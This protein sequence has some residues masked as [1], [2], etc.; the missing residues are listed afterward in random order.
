[1][2]EEIQVGDC[3][4][5]TNPQRTEVYRVIGKVTYIDVGTTFPYILSFDDS[6]WNTYGNQGG[7]QEWELSLT[8]PT[9]QRYAESRVNSVIIPLL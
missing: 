2:K 3:V 8:P 5:V 9:M 6:V 4:Q 7:F 1:M